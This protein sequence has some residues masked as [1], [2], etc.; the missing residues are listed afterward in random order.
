[1]NEEKQ[2]NELCENGADNAMEEKKKKKMMMKRA[3]LNVEER[4]A[5]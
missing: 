4:L 3:Q 1:M 5:I 2:E